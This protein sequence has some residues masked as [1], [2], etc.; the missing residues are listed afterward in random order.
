M[1][2][3]TAVTVNHSTQPHSVIHPL[4][5]IPLKRATRSSKPAEETIQPPF[6]TVSHPNTEIQKSHST[7]SGR[8]R[9]ELQASPTPVPTPDP[10]VQPEE[11]AILLQKKEYLRYNFL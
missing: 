11:A 2:T 6:P 5:D 4:L 9:E 7:R 1:R 3:V 10:P 8:N